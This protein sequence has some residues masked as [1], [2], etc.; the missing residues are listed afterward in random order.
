MNPRPRSG[1][2]L[3]ELLVVVAT[4]LVLLGIGIPIYGLVVARSRTGATEQ[5]VAGFAAAVARTGKLTV[6]VGTAAHPQLRI[7]FDF[8]R[9]GLLDG[10]P[11]LDPDFTPALIAEA[12]SLGYEGAVATAEF[13]VPRHH[14]DAAKRPLDAWRQPLRIGIGAGAYGAAD[15]GIWSIGRDGVDGTADDI[16]S[17]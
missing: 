17:W 16:R 2:T 6:T 4:I 8:D 9:N 3:V 7:L 5:L 12:E 10:R 11:D 15:V 14:L 13:T 1:F